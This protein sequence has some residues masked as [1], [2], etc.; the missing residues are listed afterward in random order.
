[1]HKKFDKKLMKSEGL[2]LENTLTTG[3]VQFLVVK[4]PI[5]FVS[6]QLSIQRTPKNT[7]TRKKTTKKPK[8]QHKKLQITLLVWSTTLQ[9]RY[10]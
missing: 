5:A 9:L 8:K 10:I 2:V 6:V 4:F 1:M 7:K 3:K